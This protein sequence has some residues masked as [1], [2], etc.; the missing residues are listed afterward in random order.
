MAKPPGLLR[1]N[2]TYYARRKVPF[3]LVSYFDKKEFKES[4]NTKDFNQAKEKLSI[5]WVQWN[6]L[7][8]EARNNKRPLRRR[9]SLKKKRKPQLSKAEALQ[10]VTAYV[11][12]MDAQS[13]EGTTHSTTLLPEEY[14]AR[15]A[16]LQD[17]IASLQRPNDPEGEMLVGSVLYDLLKENGFETNLS[18]EERLLFWSYLE[19]G[20]LE[21]AKRSKARLRK[22]FS[23]EF[24]D[25]LFGPNT[26]QSSPQ[27]TLEELC[28]SFF[29]NYKA[30]NR[31]TEKRLK[32]VQVSLNLI[33]E[34]LG[35][36]FVAS[37]LDRASCR[38]VRDT[39]AQIPVNRAKSLK[40]LSLEDAIREGTK[41]NLPTIAF[42]TQDTHLSVLFNL[43]RWGSREGLSP[44][45]DTS[46]ISVRASK[47]PSAKKRHP[48]SEEQL[49]KI[50]RAPIYRGCK[51]DERGYAEIGKNHPRRGRFWVPLIALFSGL[52]MNEICQLQIDDVKVSAKGGVI[53]DINAEDG[54]RLKT[55]D[56]VRK[57]PVHQEL[58]KIGFLSYV[59]HIRASGEKA[60]FPELP[61]GS[62]SYR[63]D[64]FSKWFRR[65]LEKAGAK[66][67]KTSFHSFR[68]NF[69]DALRQIEAPLE[70][71]SC[72][73][74]WAGS[75]QT[76]ESYG[77]GYVEGQLKDYINKI[78]YP[79]LD[80]SFLYTPEG[81]KQAET[82]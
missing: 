34:I 20:L 59:N 2:G 71:V 53:L 9:H 22:D 25:P 56:S 77:D 39:L 31:V 64:V 58:I 63:S 29:E 14:E 75:K 6:A 1:R 16:E 60:L 27:I 70:I 45:I 67:P 35:A 66:A 52:R 32:K 76:R 46:D 4:L 17:S 55:Q 33:K 42:E 69:R 8:D 61:E 36:T 73:G 12:K 40:G 37:E 62:T 54:K 5:K 79:G 78:C 48:F 41:S 26:P 24:F 18:D 28:Q 10:I 50:F 72:L 21:L 30:T 68:H 38:L 49:I 51:D 7:F 74:G 3:D 82:N 44:T 47:T 19:R 81:L 43:V 80:L 13:K 57:V 15:K 23:H 65:F 11:A